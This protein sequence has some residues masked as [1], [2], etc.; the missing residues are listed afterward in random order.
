MSSMEYIRTELAEE[1]ELYTK[2]PSASTPGSAGIDLYLASE[3]PITLH[4]SIP[5]ELRTGLHIWTNDDSIMG[6]LAPRSSSKY[7]LTNTIGAI[8]SDYQGELII[9]AISNSEDDVVTFEPGDKFAQIFLM[10]VI[11]PCRVAWAEMDNFSRGTS[12][13]S[14]GFGSTGVRIMR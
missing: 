10:P 9:K 8:D 3:R 4:H 1:L 11:A 2:G 14:N 13:G 7:R 6:V 12:R 5:T